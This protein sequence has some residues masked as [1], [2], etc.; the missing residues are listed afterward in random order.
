MLA[1]KLIVGRKGLL[2][3]FIQVYI[4]VIFIHNKAHEDSLGDE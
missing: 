3:L 4:H 2:S 1:S